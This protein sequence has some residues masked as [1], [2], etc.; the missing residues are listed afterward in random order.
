MLIIRR[1]LLTLCASLLSVGL[2]LLVWSH[3][4]AQTIRDP[5][6]IKTWLAES[7]VYEELVPAI[8]ESN[9]NTNDGVPLDDPRIMAIISSA[10][11]PEFLAL[12]TETVLSS[13][14]VWLDGTTTAPEF[15]IDLNGPKTKLVEGVGAYASETAAS[16][17]V[18]TPGQPVSAQTALD[19]FNA[20]CL[21]AG[22]SPAQVGE[23]A[24]QE[25]LGSQNFLSDATF[26][27]EDIL[28]AQTSTGQTL[29]E[30]IFTPQAQR[31]YHFG[32]FAVVL[33]LGVSTLAL[34]GVIL[35]SGTKRAGCR[36]A[37]FIVGSAGLFIVISYIFTRLI[38]SWAARPRT[39]TGELPSTGSTLLANIATTVG[40]DIS[41]LLGW[42]S[43]GL[44]VFGVALF[45]LSTRLKASTASSPTTQATV[46]GDNQP[47]EP[48]RPPTQKTD[49]L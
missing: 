24:K 33:A 31:V 15:S 13:I 21:P 36:R 16:L 19:V 23:Q 37:A 7:G 5:E 11:S 25:L 2:L 35:L 34:I 42:Y 20:A 48:P 9:Q 32:G 17:P 41:G 12:S 46:P 18:C 38:I 8:L 10:F 40:G 1:L 14:F 29:G 28:G 49:L 45:V 6:V 44:V 30:T 47:D 22:V 4:A 26:N 3:I 43:L 27:A 39:D